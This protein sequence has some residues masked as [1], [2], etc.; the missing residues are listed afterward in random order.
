MSRHELFKP[1]ESSRVRNRDHRSMM[2]NYIYHFAR[3]AVW[4]QQSDAMH[5]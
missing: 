4:Q 1:D 3:H 5:Q 2:N